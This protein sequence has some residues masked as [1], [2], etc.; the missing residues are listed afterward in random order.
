MRAQLGAVRASLAAL[1]RVPAGTLG[2]LALYVLGGALVL[3]VAAWGVTAGRPALEDAL[4]HHV[5]PDGWVPVLAPVLRGV[6]RGQADAV[7]VNVTLAVGT[8][9]VAALL[10]PVKERLSRAFERGQRWAP[11]APAHEPPF[12]NEALDETWFFLLCLAAQVTLLWVGMSPNPMRRVAA[13]VLSTMF[14]WM[15]L[16][17]DFGSPAL[18]R[19]GRGLA[20]ILRVLLHRPVAALLFGAALA[21][22]A[23]LV[24]WALS[25]LRADH[26][27]ATLAVLCAASLAGM[28]AAV[29]AGTR[30]AAFLHD[31]PVPPLH[32]LRRGLAVLGL[33]AFIAL[34]AVATGLAVRAIHHTSQVLKCRYTLVPGSWHV[35]AGVLDALLT[36]TVQ[37]TARLDVDVQNPTPY[38]VDLHAVT[39]EVL[40][41]G[42]TIAAP[43]V[44]D[45][46]VPAGTVRRQHLSL[47]LP[48]G[49]SHLPGW[50][51]LAHL[52]DLAD[53]DWALRVRLAFLPLSEI[54]VDVL[55][56][57]RR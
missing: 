1:G 43:P 38:D 11:P 12:L 14:V 22:P 32:G 4:L 35:D 27:G 51:D 29:L 46:V 5:L 41:A 17:A 31:V 54:A 19:R 48:V 53:T 2:P 42:D 52:A 24:G 10:F 37:V 33:G 9:L 57:S 7:F 3:A 16:A 23:Q 56:A 40:H 18:Q 8:A 15:Q 44:G 13:S 47:T 45:L 20:G 28:T 25:G 6:F 30:L 50:A 26:P 49:A 34:N 39:V 55:G 36:G 21:G